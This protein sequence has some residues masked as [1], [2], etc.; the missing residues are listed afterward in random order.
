MCWDCAYTET[1]IGTHSKYNYSPQQNMFLSKYM[2]GDTATVFIEVIYN[3][4][5]GVS[6][7][8]ELQ[9][10]IVFD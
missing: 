2:K 5:V 7:T 6:V 3:S 9:L 10:K 1:I 8:K 4:D